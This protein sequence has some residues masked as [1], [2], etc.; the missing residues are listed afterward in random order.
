MRF[1]IECPK[2]GHEYNDD[3]G[4]KLIKARAGYALFCKCGFA[5]YIKFKIKFGV[6]D[7]SNIIT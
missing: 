7:D 1:Y 4:S 2:C 5:G 6:K 3:E